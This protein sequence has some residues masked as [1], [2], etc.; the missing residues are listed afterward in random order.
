M[1]KECEY[2]AAISKCNVA[3]QPGSIMCQVYRLQSGKTKEDLNKRREGH[4]ARCPHC[5]KELY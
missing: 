3:V 4:A 5:G 1:N 2:C